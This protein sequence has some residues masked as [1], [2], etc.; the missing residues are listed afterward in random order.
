MIFWAPVLH[1]FLYL[2]PCYKTFQFLPQKGGCILLLLVFGFNHVTWEDINRQRHRTDV[3]V[4]VCLDIPSMTLP[5]PWEELPL[6]N[7]FPFSLGPRI[8]TWGSQPPYPEVRKMFIIVW[9][10]DSVDDCYAAVADWYTVVRAMVIIANLFTSIYR[11]F[12]LIILR[13]Q[14]VQGLWTVRS[15]LVQIQALQL[16]VWFRHSTSLNLHVLA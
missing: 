15:E 13:R 16:T 5:S 6:G 8:N 4:L 3:K 9:H 12:I 14:K 11:E 7:S 1:P 10:Q 2:H